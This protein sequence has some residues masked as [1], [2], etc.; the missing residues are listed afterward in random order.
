MT[1]PAVPALLTRD[2]VAA[3]LGVTTETLRIWRADPEMAFPKPLR[4]SQRT[5][6][7]TP[8]QIAQWIASR[9]EEG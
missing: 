3:L 6:R 5:T 1:Q 2:E 9:Q 8:E 4:F 7:W